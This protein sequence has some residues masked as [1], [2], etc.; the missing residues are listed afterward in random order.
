M[1]AALLARCTSCFFFFF[2]TMQVHKTA[3]PAGVEAAV[4]AAV[5]AEAEAEHLGSPVASSK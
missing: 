3:A 2:F 5:E 4:E 1:Y